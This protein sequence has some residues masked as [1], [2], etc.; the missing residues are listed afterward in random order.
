MTKR[1]RMC[2]ARRCSASN[3]NS[4]LSCYAERLDQA[5]PAMRPFC[6]ISIRPYVYIRLIDSRNDNYILSVHM[7]H[8]DT[9]HLLTAKCIH[10]TTP[11]MA[12]Y[13]GLKKK[14][15][16]FGKLA[17]IALNKFFKRHEY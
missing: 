1:S 2:V 17:Y 13:A 5:N 10:E 8:S 12:V 15:S 14:K 6:P 7:Q 16:V 11:Y 3:S 9:L 4:H